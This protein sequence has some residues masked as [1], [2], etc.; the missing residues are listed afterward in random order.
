MGMGVELEGLELKRFVNGL[1]EFLTGSSR[2]V[3][4]PL[5]VSRQ[6][7]KRGF[8]GGERSE[9]ARMESRQEISQGAGQAAY[10]ASE[11][12]KGGTKTIG[13]GLE[14]TGDAVTYTGIATAQPEIVAAGETISGTGTAMN[15]IVD[16]SDGKPIENV[17]MEA[18]VSVGFGELGK[19]GVK[20]TQ[21]A[22]GE[23]FVK[24]GANKVSESII[25]GTVKV[26]EKLFDN[27]VTP[28]ILPSQQTTVPVYG[29]VEEPN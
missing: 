11:A 24:S 9:I 16:I 5:N 15:A 27:Y 26:Y 14:V 19:A 21:K 28:K 18:A 6:M 7:D 2:M 20:A 17:A 29:P 10:G 3:S 25:E 4:E 8:R 1:K 22:A 23:E 12:I 13:E